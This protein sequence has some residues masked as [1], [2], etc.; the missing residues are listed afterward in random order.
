LNPG[1]GLETQR[2]E[3]RAREYINDPT[4]NILSPPIQKQHGPL[5]KERTIGGH[6]IRLDSTTFFFNDHQL[7]LESRHHYDLADRFYEALIVHSSKL[8]ELD[9]V[10]EEQYRGRTNRKWFDISGWEVGPTAIKEL[11]E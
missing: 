8:D 2:H 3:F 4:G 6:R 1:G 7:Y 10:L 9:Q 11:L 5:I